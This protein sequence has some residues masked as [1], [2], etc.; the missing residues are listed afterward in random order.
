MAMIAD[1]HLDAGLTLA[2]GLVTGLVPLAAGWAVTHWLNR[3]VDVPLSQTESGDPEAP[4]GR[5]PVAVALQREEDLPSLAESL[6]PI[7]LPVLLLTLASAA[8]GFG[9]PILARVPSPAVS[10]V[11]QAVRFAGNANVALL[12]GTA[13]AVGLLM[14]QR[15]L[16]LGAAGVLIAPPLETAAV[17][18][19]IIAAGG[20]FGAML[21]NAGVGDAIKAAAAGVNVSLILLSWAVALV[22][23]IAQGSATVAMLTT[24]A[25]VAPLTAAAR[26]AGQLPYHPV[27]LFLAIGYGAFG[28]SWMN[29]SGFWLVS[30]LGGLTEKQTLK[31]WTV[32]LT[33][34]SVVGLGTTLVLAKVLPLW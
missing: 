33:V 2:F 14:R 32:L 5:E 9:R 8:A 27:Y 34:S 6:A 3:R 25:M 31:T 10:G 13:M 30:R 23:R 28:A 16:T 15:G 24:S 17:M 18:I 21:K 20:A 11:L 12:V 26:D 1:F 29:D 7:V 19:L 22:L 4:P